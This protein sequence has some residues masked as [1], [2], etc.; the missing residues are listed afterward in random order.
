MP[1][2]VGALSFEKLV[3]S[4]SKSS[5]QEVTNDC[6]PEAGEKSLSAFFGNDLPES[7]YQTSVVG[8]GVKLDSGLDPIETSQLAN[9]VERCS[10]WKPTHPRV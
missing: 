9:L 2:P 10:V 4:K 3:A 7:T 1:K 8:D 5:L 6:R